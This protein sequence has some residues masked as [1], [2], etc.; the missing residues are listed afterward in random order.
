[1]IEKKYTKIN[2]QG[3]WKI[4]NSSICMHITRMGGHL[5]P[6][7]FFCED[8]FGKVV[9]ISPYFIN[10]WESSYAQIED[11]LLKPL[12]GDF[13]CLP[14]GNDNRYGDEIHPD[15]GE[16]ATALWHYDSSQVKN[17]F[18]IHNFFMHT[19][20]REGKIVKRVGLKDGESAIY[21]EHN[22]EGFVGDS[23]YGHHAILNVPK[24]NN[25]LLVSTSPY[26]FGLTSRRKN[27]HSNG[28]DEYFFIEDNK[29]FTSLK[30]VPTVWKDE[31]VV[32]CTSFPHHKGFGGTVA[33]FYDETVKIAWSCAVNL[34]EKFLWFSFKDPL[35]FPGFLIWI[36]NQGRKNIPWNGKTE[37]LGLIDMC[38]N[39]AEGLG[40]SVEK[41]ILNDLGIPTA[42]NFSGEQTSF[43]YIEGVIPIPTGFSIVERIEFKDDLAIFY[44]ATGQEVKTTI[45]I[46]FLSR[47]FYL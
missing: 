3:C 18:E 43:R 35:V 30:K 1:M 47:G 33:V 10:L 37:C 7:T 14:F 38:G 32:D 2:G 19:R 29:I 24:H 9:N 40:S 5:G 26:K 22:V 11:E 27:S 12:R 6:V 45:D 46:S 28:S 39:L 44:S 42:H 34:E 16:S 8:E 20:V 36:E 15:H 17:S 31:P 13:F 4:E 21:L 23:S 25:N 41:N